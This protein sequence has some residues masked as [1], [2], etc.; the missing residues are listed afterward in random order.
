MVSRQWR[1]L[2][3]V[4]D[5]CRHKLESAV[6]SQVETFTMNPRLVEKHSIVDVLLTRKKRKGI[7][8]ESLDV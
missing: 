2:T 5:S 7:Q 4:S 6:R 3:S 1:W 8:E